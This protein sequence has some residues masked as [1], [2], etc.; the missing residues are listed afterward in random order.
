M[1]L[2][3]EELWDYALGL[4]ADNGNR[5][6]AMCQF[7]SGDLYFSQYDKAGKE[8]TRF[9]GGNDQIL[10]G[11]KKGLAIRFQEKDV[12]A[13]GRPAWRSWVIRRHR[14]WP[15]PR[16]GRRTSRGSR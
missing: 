2:S 3:D 7:A 15:S 5:A 14:P 8:V 9:T 16:R 6:T 12:R 13:M 4:K 11:T 1:A 10:L